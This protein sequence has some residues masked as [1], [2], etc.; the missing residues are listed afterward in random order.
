MNIDQRTAET[1]RRELQGRPLDRAE[2]LNEMNDRFDRLVKTGAIQ[3]ERY[4]L[5][6]I[7]PMSMTSS[8]NFA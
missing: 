6:P 4:N 7:N 1:V 8:F 5:A 2:H 3:P